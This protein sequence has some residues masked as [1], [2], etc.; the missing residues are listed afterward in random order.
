MFDLLGMYTCM[1]IDA[2]LVTE[3]QIVWCLWWG[4]TQQQDGHH[5]VRVTRL[6]AAFGPIRRIRMNRLLTVRFLIAYTRCFT[7]ANID[8]YIHMIVCGCSMWHAL[9][10]SAYMYF[11]VGPHS[12]LIV[13]LSMWS[14]DDLCP[15]ESEHGCLINTASEATITVNDF[16]AAR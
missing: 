15:V 11:D 3:L 14:Y 4:V 2:I 7:P 5:C 1:T 8:Q 9:E 10:S 13:C 12:H 6:K 16:V